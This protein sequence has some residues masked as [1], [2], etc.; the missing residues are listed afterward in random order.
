[1]FREARLESG[2][3]LEA[4]LFSGTPGR[5]IYGDSGYTKVL[6]AVLFSGTPGRRVYG[7]SGYTKVLKAT[8]FS[9]NPGGTGGENGKFLKPAGGDG[10]RRL[11]MGGGGYLTRYWKARGTPRWCVS[12]GGR[13]KTGMHRCRE[14]RHEM[15]DVDVTG[16]PGYRSLFALP[17]FSHPHDDQDKT[18]ESKETSPRGKEQ[19]VVR[20]LHLRHIQARLPELAEEHG[21][22]PSKVHGGGEVGPVLPGELIEV[23]GNPR[24]GNCIDPIDLSVQDPRFTRLGIRKFIR[25]IGGCVQHHGWD[26]Q[27]NSGSQKQEKDPDDDESRSPFA[28]IHGGHPIAGS[29]PFPSYQGITCNST[30]P[31]RGFLVRRCAVRTGVGDC[32]VLIMISSLRPDHSLWITVAIVLRQR[33]P[34]P[35]DETGNRNPYGNVPWSGM[36]ISERHYLTFRFSRFDALTRFEERGVRKG[37]RNAGIRPGETSCVPHQVEI[38]HNPPGLDNQFLLAASDELPDGDE[39]PL[40]ADLEGS[41]HLHPTEHHMA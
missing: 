33:S 38:V 7:D 6:K 32:V 18:Q 29:L 1:M 39:A 19:C 25:K 36:G 28:L 21:P 30:D 9:G 23:D 10:C 20:D 3:F 24:G 40:L 8:L 34:Y 35:G 14:T 37:G 41:R 11:L 5:R 15:R 4:T 2:K 27:E 31:W 16:I 13:G 22:V 17:A 26:R 12:C